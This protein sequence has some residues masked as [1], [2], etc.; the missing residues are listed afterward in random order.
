MVSSVQL[1]LQSPL[2]A[3]AR[4]FPSVSVPSVLPHPNK[5]HKEMDSASD[6]A[7]KPTEAPLLP[8]SAFMSSAESCPPVTASTVDDQPLYS[9]PIKKGHSR[10]K[11]VSSAAAASSLMSETFKPQ[12]IE[13][14][15]RSTAFSEEKTDREFLSSF[16]PLPTENQSKPKTSSIEFLHEERA[17]DQ[18]SRQP[19]SSPRNSVGSETS[20]PSSF[21]PDF[22]KS[23]DSNTNHDIS[24]PGGFGRRSSSAEVL[25]EFSPGSLKSDVS[26]GFES[27]ETLLSIG[28]SASEGNDFDH[29]CDSGI[30]LDKVSDIDHR[31]DLQD[32]K[33]ADDEDEAEMKDSGVFLKQASSFSSLIGV[34]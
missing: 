31:L 21:K 29:N 7:R 27:S 34:L 15:A 30:Q 18:L 28:N 2:S 9:V 1:T 11:P 23:V 14:Q 3:T 19:D 16:H 8:P 32:M 5:S 13:A 26:R 17:H 12:V 20:I 24:P 22:K 25:D 10:Q 33:F 6:N 4:L